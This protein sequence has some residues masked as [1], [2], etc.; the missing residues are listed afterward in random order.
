MGVS[1]PTVEKWIQQGLPVKKRGAPGVP[2]QINSAEVFRWIE[3]RAKKSID[4]AE[5]SDERELRRRKLAAE[6]LKAELDLTKARGGVVPLSELELA[7]ADVFAQVKSNLRL[8]PA[9][10]A[11]A[12]SA[13]SKES[14][15]KSL[16]L[17]EIDQALES[18]ADFD[19]QP[20]D[21]ELEF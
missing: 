10:V 13:E 17:Q 5:L 9:R 4:S 7:L 19:W 20:A 8:I 15:I 1:Q 11:S 3:D 14:K 6:T 21:D 18:L 16:I 12:V 2:S